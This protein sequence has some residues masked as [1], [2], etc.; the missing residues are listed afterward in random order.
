MEDD[1]LNSLIDKVI[2]DLKESRLKCIGNLTNLDRISSSPQL[3]EICDIET[4]IEFFNSWEV[5]ISE[6]GKRR[7]NDINLDQVLILVARINDI[8]ED[9]HGSCKCYAHNLFNRNSKFHE[10]GNILN[11]FGVGNSNNV[12]FNIN[13]LLRNQ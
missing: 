11:H 7:M 6:S 12:M 5:M 13:S 3:T 8:V 1:Q 2:S 9:S 4:E 10:L